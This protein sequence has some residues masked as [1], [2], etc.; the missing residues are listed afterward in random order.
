[1]KQ[2]TRTMIYILIAI[3]VVIIGTIAILSSR[4]AKPVSE[5]HLDLDRIYLADLSYDKDILEFKEAIKIDPKDPELYIELANPYYDFSY[6]GEMYYSIETRN[7]SI[8]LSTRYY[9]VAQFSEGMDMIGQRILIS[10]VTTRFQNKFI[11][12]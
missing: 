4:T 2:K 1:M 3:A 10:I 5:S 7:S 11:W 12:G 9:Y 6:K 8:N